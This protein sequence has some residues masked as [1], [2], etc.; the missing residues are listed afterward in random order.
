LKQ[1]IEWS[2]NSQYFSLDSGTEH[3]KLLAYL[4]KELQCK[5][6]IDIGH[7]HGFSSVALSYDNSK[8]VISFDLVNC[9][10]QSPVTSS[11]NRENIEFLI[12]DCLLSQTFKDAIQSGECEM[13]MLD[14]DHT[15]VT[16]KLI[17]EEL[18]RLNYKGLVLL[19][20]INLNQEMRAF[21]DDIPE[22][23]MD[24]SRYGHWSG[25]GI[26]IFDDDKYGI[27]LT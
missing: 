24:I 22:K 16:E 8:K 11:I 23:K 2:P 9:L 26:V 6:I 14:I 3:Y 21:F 27:L 13:I 1:Y 20:D 15:G 10:P 7:Y 19:D 12:E 4:S 18:R 5:K 25:T 17:M